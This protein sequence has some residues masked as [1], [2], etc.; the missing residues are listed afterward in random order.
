MANTQQGT[1]L[2]KSLVV[3]QFAASLFLL[4]GTLTVYNQIQFMRQQS[5]GLDIHKT[6]VVVPPI[7]T[8]STYLNQMLAF[9]ENLLKIP[10]VKS[11]AASTTIPGQPVNWNAGGIKLVSQGQEL[12]KQYRVIGV[13]YDYINQFGLKL[14]AGRSFSEE[15]GYRSGG[16]DF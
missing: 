12:A 8:D 14:I 10:S 6:L 9:K 1:L 3:F 15:F 11:V 7:V 13:D 5:L 4:I 16:C 2:R